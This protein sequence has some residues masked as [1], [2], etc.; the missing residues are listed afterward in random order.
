MRALP[1]KVLAQQDEGQFWGQ[2]GIVAP[3]PA[4]GCLLLEMIVSKGRELQDGASNLWVK[5]KHKCTTDTAPGRL[6]GQKDVWKAA[7]PGDGWGQE[8]PTRGLGPLLALCYLGQ[9]LCLHGPVCLSVDGGRLHTAQGHGKPPAEPGRRT[10]GNEEVLEHAWHYCCSERKGK[11]DPSQDPT[12]SLVSCFLRPL[13]AVTISQTALVFD[14]LD[15]SG[16]VFCRLFLNWF[17]SGVD[18]WSGWDYGFLGGRPESGM[19]FASCRVRGTWLTTP[20]VDLGHLA[21]AAFVAFLHTSFFCSL[22]LLHSLKGSHPPSPYWSSE[23]SCSTSPVARW[24]HWLFEMVLHGRFVCPSLNMSSY[25]QY[26]ILSYSHM[27]Q[28]GIMHTY[29]MLILFIIQ[30]SFILLFKL[31]QL[32]PSRA[33]WNG[34]CVPLTHLHHLFFW[35]HSHVLAFIRCSSLIL[36]IPH[37]PGINYVSKKS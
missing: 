4:S 17:L 6:C 28:C 9:S 3:V 15:S 11:G 29:F 8:S 30:Y 32:W 35:T 33:L 18:S 12:W 5:L 20:G 22:S 14:D 7:W 1:M 21:E 37:H 23:E 10:A 27:H 19:P 26:G 31:P 34:C 16:Q 36:Y 2:Q 13:L 25:Y 24:L